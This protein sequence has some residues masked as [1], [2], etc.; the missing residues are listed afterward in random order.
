M[1][2]GIFGLYFYEESMLFIRQSNLTGS[3]V[4]SFAQSANLKHLKFHKIQSSRD[5][6]LNNRLLIPS[7]TVV[8]PLSCSPCSGHTDLLGG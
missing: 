3:L 4:F 6:D 7:L 5:L 1:S 8:H 2:H